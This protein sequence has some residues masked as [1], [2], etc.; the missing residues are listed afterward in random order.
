[1]AIQFFYHDNI[2]KEISKLERKIIAIRQGFSIFERLCETQFHPTA[3]Q[4]VITPAKLHR[5]AQNSI[6]S[7][8]KTELVVP[9]SGLRPNQ[10]PRLWFA[11][12]GSDIV[13]L[14]IASHIDSYDDEEINNIA[15]SRASDF[16]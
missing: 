4:Q 7:L 11:V 3:P 15:L 13:F 1:M 12:K 2:Q 14:C 10:W 8:W 9:K 16:F 6:W 5:L